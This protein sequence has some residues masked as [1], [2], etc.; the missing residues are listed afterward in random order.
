MSDDIY[1][2]N[3]LILM[4]NDSHIVDPLHVYLHLMFGFITFASYAAG[5]NYRTF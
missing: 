4:F 2:L 1:L 5:Q 3:N